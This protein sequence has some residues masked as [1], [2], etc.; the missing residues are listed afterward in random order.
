MTVFVF[1][2]PTLAPDEARR[3]WEVVYLPPASQGDVYRAAAT[4][5]VAIGIIDGNFDQVPA[6]WHK[7]ILWAIEQGIHVFGSA[8]M[9]ALRAAELAAFGM[10]G[11]GKIFQAYRDGEWE[12]DDEVAVVHGPAAAGFRA[13][14][15][16]MVNIRATLER[17]EREAVIEPETRR[18]LERLAKALFYPER[19]YPRLLECAQRERL[20][21]KQLDAFRAW[22]PGGRVDLKRADALEMLRTM[23]ERLA[24]NPAPPQASFRLEYTKFWDQFLQSAGVLDAVADSGAETVSFEDLLDELR[25]DPNAYLEAHRECLL[26]E[27]IVEQARRRG[28][29]PLPEKTRSRAEAFRQKHGLEQPEAFERWLRERQLTPERFDEWMQQEALIHGVGLELWQ[30]VRRGLPALLRFSPGYRGWLERARQKVRAL[31]RAG[32]ANEDWTNDPDALWDWYL[33]ELSPDGSSLSQS[34][35]REISPDENEAMLRA[36]ARHR[37]FQQLQPGKSKKS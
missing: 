34:I 30:R 15:E 22:L 3:E 14:S 28:H 18:A 25:L 4:G 19:A 33:T 5:P 26:R 2:G 35:L 6:V 16:A 13:A 24:R 31:A 29:A 36:R 32:A 10:H 21:A 23:R 7:E 1:T 11:V 27:L 17:A 12:D 37:R 8:S 9:G 20:P